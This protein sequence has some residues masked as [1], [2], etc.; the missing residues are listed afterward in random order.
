VRNTVLLIL[1]CA[2]IAAP[3]R[4]PLPPRR[5]G[6]LKQGDVAPDFNLKRLHSEKT[7]R[8][9]SFRNVKPVA[10]VFGSYT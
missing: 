10:L 5:E 4:G 6:T 8:L 2:A 3:Q 9:S 1:A 7:L